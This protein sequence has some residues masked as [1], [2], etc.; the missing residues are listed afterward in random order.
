MK[1]FVEDYF[2]R[3]KPITVALN[4]LQSNDALIRDAVEVWFKFECDLQ[5]CLTEQ[6]DLVML[7]KRKKIRTNTCSLLSKF[8]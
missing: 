2:D 1:R 8:D 5:E 7:I 6:K 4:I 3:F